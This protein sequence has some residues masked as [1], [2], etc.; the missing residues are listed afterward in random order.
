[1]AF[2]GFPIEG[3]EFYEQLDADN[4][5]EFWARERHRYDDGVKPLFAALL[6]HATA[7]GAPAYRAQ[8][9][10]TDF[11]LDPAKPNPTRV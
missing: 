7:G 5:R 3:I 11:G 4:S 1:M 6:D 9:A 8:A 2:T 10:L